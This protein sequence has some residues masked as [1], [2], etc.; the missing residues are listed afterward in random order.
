[1]RFHFDRL[2]RFVLGAIAYF[3]LSTIWLYALVDTGLIEDRGAFTWSVLGLVGL[4]HVVFGYLF[5]EWVGVLFPLALIL[6]AMP[7]GYPVSEFGEPSPVWVGQF[8]YS[9]F[10]VVLVAAGIGLRNLVELRRSPRQAYRSA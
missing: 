1:M 7:A 2:E 8:F 5:R 6:V 9:V 3:G 10:E 4:A